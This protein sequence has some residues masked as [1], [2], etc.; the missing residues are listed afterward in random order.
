[1][2]TVDYAI[3]AA[4]AH[5]RGDTSIAYGEG[6]A[7]Q[8]LNLVQGG[9]CARFVRQVHETSLGLLPFSW[10]FAA[11][12][13]R[14]MVTRMRHDGKLINTG[15]R[16][17]GDV[18]QIGTGY[19]GHVAIYVGDV[20]GV[21]CIAENTSDQVRGNPRAAGTKLTPW[22]TLSSRVTGVFRLCVVADA[23][24]PDGIKLVLQSGD[25][26]TVLTTGGMLVGDTL[27]VPAREVGE[28]L[29]YTVTDHTQDQRKAYWS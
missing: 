7:R 28:A 4:R 27:L 9:M 8:V 5:Q 24:E 23:D 22:S 3:E 10:E 16:R 17:P 29:G 15:D 18:L 13:A 11:P 14:D 2:Q 19:P 25:E 21:E 12:C 20:D 1:M 6:A 26:A